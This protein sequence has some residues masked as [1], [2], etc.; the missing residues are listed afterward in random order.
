MSKQTSW[1]LLEILEQVW[2]DGA[3]LAG[4]AYLG[5]KTL[6]IAEA[7]PA[8]LAVFKGLPAM[9]EEINHQ[10]PNNANGVAWRNV[11]EFIDA[12]NALREELLAQLE[13]TDE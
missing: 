3:Q 9:Q 1:Q 5:K 2:L 12:R 7:M 10:H 6:R 4:G 8:I 11:Q 13:G